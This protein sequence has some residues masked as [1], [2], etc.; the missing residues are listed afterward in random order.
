MSQRPLWQPDP[1]AAASSHMQVFWRKVE[2]RRGRR[3]ADYNQFHHWSVALRGQ[4]WSD[5]WDYCGVLGE[6][7]DAP[8]IEPDGMLSAQ[9][10]PDAHLNFARNLLRNRGDGEALVF[11]GE[12]V[13]RRSVSHDE[14]YAQVAQCAAAMRKVG[15]TEGDRV[16]AYMPTLPETVVVMLAAAS[17]GAIFS[18]LAPDCSVED[19][20]EC[21]GQ[22]QPRLLFVA[23]SCLHE[24]KTQSALERVVEIAGRLPDLLGVVVVP[25]VQS[26]AKE[27]DA[28]RA[29]IP[30]VCSWADHL[31]P[32]AAVT[33][34]DFVEL[35]F[36]FPL[37]ITFSHGI[38]GAL[39]CIAHGAG[40][41]L[42]QHLK[43][44]Q[45]HCDIRAG[46][47][48]FFSANCSQAIWYWLV[49]ALGSGATL[50]L[51][52]GSPFGRSE[53]ALWDYAEGEHF[54]HFGAP[55]DYFE[56]LLKRGIKPVHTHDLNHLR[57]LM[58]IESNLTEEISNYVYR[59]IKQT[60]WLNAVS[61]CPDT[62]S[63]FLLGNP[64]EPVWYAD[65][66]YKALG[67]G[68]AVFDQTGRAVIGDEGEL[69]CTESFPSMPVMIWND[70]DGSRYRQAYFRHFPNIWSRG[71]RGRETLRGCIMGC[72]K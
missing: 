59:N 50:M 18:A 5:L 3:F 47:R 40:G 64:L 43:E 62:L 7:G 72:G 65:V 35:P 19:V 22:I 67:M 56:T 28:A 71:T 36:S 63:C 29:A 33:Q 66:Q 26:D 16:A 17:M 48:L 54:T 52:D 32:Y 70:P 69:V 55:L 11:R 21:F 1:Y 34:I 24:G 45:L 38:S 8:L 58:T 31:A 61:G 12:D 37:Y 25:Y 9:W 30:K 2:K 49:S 15:V 23:D 41:T 39:K 6:K 44:H 20:S 14:L 68:V 53:N 42:L 46:D 10:F 60:L 27:M 57:S 4:F 13:V 51:Y